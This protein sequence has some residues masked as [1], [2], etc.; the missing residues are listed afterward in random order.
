MSYTAAI[1]QL[2]GLLAANP[3]SANHPGVNLHYSPD[4]RIDTLAELDGFV[5]GAF[6]LVAESPGNLYPYVQGVEPSE[7]FTKLRLEVCTLL[8]TDVLVEDKTAESRAR[9]IMETV[10]LENF[11]NFVLFDVGEPSRSRVAQDRRIIWTLRF[12]MRYS[13]S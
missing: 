6:L 2:K 9:A 4:P 11:S 3:M 7:Y 5:D 12:S 13:E 10:T 8:H 1:D